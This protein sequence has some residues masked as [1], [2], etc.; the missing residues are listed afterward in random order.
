MAIKT[1]FGVALLL[2]L[3]LIAWSLRD[4][5]AVRR[6][7]HPQTAR[8]PNIQFDN[9]T[10]R[11]APVASDAAAMPI[12]APGGV[13]KCQRRD[14]VIYTDRTCPEGME[15]QALSKGS[16]TVLPAT[17]VKREAAKPAPE[18]DLKEKRI[19]RIVNQ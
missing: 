19:E 17:P 12:R 14:K 10:V 11:Q 3:G 15:E 5:D 13:R 2:L 9:G 18:I 1:V 4:S 8:P 7:T 16:V 6:I